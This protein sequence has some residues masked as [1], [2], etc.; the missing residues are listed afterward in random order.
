[1]SPY[2]PNQ[3]QKDT[4]PRLA[5]DL[6]TETPKRIKIGSL[7]NILWQNILLAYSRSRN[8]NLPS[9]E[10]RRTHTVKFLA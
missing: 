1:M 4:I 9:A 10:H 5:N 3:T 2:E 7:E 6:R 8:L